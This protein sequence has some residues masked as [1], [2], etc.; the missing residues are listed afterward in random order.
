M[1]FRGWGSQFCEAAATSTLTLPATLALTVTENCAEAPLASPARDQVNTLA[2]RAQSAVHDTS[3]SVN[4]S[5]TSATTLLAVPGPALA[6]V[7]V[8]VPVAPAVRLAGQDKAAE[9]S[10]LVDTPAAVT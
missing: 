5:S 1:L 4:G 7:S 2:C 6:T 3:D 8:Q 9:M 10:A